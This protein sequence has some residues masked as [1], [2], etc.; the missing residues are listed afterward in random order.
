MAWFGQSLHHGL[1]QISNSEPRVTWRTHLALLLL[2]LVYI[3]SYIDRQVVAILIEPIKSEF[4][5]SDTQIGLL[6]GLAFGL[7]YAV[8]GLPVGRMADK[9]TRR[10]IVA[11]CCSL[12]SLATLACGLAAQFWQLLL[13]RMSVAVG[14]AGGMAPSLSLVSDMYPKERR[15]LAISL[16]MLGSPFGALFGLAL[17][18]WVAQHYGWRVTFIA[19]G[20]PGMVL[21]LLVWWLVREPVRGGFD[22]P[23]ASVPVSSEPL[24]RQVWRLLGQPAFRYVAMAC[25]V[26]GIAAYGYGIWTPSFLVRTHGMTLSQAGVLFGVTT[27]LSSIVGSV[28]CGWLCD[29]LTLRDAR[30]QV[31]LPMIGV[32]LAVPCALAFFLWP[33]G[34]FWMMGTW[35]VPHAMVFAA[36]FGFFAC[37]WPTLSYSAVS[38]M[39]AAHER[40]VAS[41]TLNL[42]ITLLGVGGGP[43]VT[44]I[45][46]DVMTPL[47]GADALRWALAGVSCLLLVTVLLFAASVQPYRGALARLAT[48]SPSVR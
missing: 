2:T 34:Q 30:W 22:G 31:A 12:W 41:A 11:V 21:G 45:L 14:E 35:Q 7:L 33:A 36:G 5:A 15:S 32:A 24:L 39:V 38:Q 29:R 20:L 25:G 27:G 42:F 1:M 17:G 28:F 40:S 3:F 4:A 8:L 37:W 48:A 26:A 10:T 23:S 47:F 9:G 13:A 44:G 19:F 43:L 18:G 16:F 46:S 6:T